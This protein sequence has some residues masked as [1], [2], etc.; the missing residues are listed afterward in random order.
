MFGIVIILRRTKHSAELKSV[1]HSANHRSYGNENVDNVRPAL[2][3]NRLMESSLS[4]CD[5]T[6]P[7]RAN[8]DEVPNARPLASTSAMLICTEAWSFEVMRRS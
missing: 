2:V 6:C 3:A 4:P 1:H 8:V 5:R 7:Q